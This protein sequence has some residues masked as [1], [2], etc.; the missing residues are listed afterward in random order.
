[1]RSWLTENL[2]ASNPGSRTQTWQTTAPSTEEEPIYSYFQLY[3]WTDKE[4]LICSVASL[5]PTKH[6]NETSDKGFF[7]YNCPASSA[8]TASPHRT[9]LKAL[10]RKLP[11][12]K[13]LR[14]LTR[15]LFLY[16]FI[17]FTFS[18][19]LINESTCRVPFIVQ[20]ENR[21]WPKSHNVL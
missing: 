10:Q 13:C 3:E 17:G 8:N 2:P 19:E 12:P 11:S 6:K 20:H 5:V 21:W 7:T 9:Q 18:L 4:V 15:F 16:V 1:M 14:F